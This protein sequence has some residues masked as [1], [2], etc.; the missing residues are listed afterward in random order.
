VEF[1]TTGGTTGTPLAVGL[2]KRT[3]AIR[4][5]F[6]WRFYN[7][8]GYSFGDKCA[9]IR[10]IEVHGFAKGR[11]MEYDPHLNYLILSAFD[12]NNQNMQ[13]YI[14]KLCEFRPKF[15]QGYPSN[16]QL[17]ARFSAD[18]GLVVNPHGTLKGIITSSETLHPFQRHQISEVF[19]APVYD[20]YGNTE[21]AGRLGQCEYLEGYHEFSEHSVI[22]IVDEDSSGVGEIVATPLINYA[23]PLI[24]YRTGDSIRRATE[25]CRC[26]RALP[27]L[28][29]LEGRKQDAALLKDGTPVS[30]TGFFFAVH[31]PEMSR[32]RKI[33]FQQEAPGHLRAV[34]VKGEHYQEGACEAM[35]ERMNR[36][37]AKPFQIEI[38][39][40]DE[41]P[42]TRAGKHQFFV[43]RIRS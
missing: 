19:G 5:A 4:L 1:H 16:L 42:T 9:V 38:Q 28:A 27:M 41:I 34:V 11:R 23:M 12:M 17:L 21:Q 29:S 26:G 30:L 14:Q 7:W 25:R 36:N 32:L 2:E 20:L 43:S 37:L 3:N 18:E 6:E 24:R 35:L 39:Y 8:A 22:E 15:I 13:K 10:G 31:V 40:V 33:Q